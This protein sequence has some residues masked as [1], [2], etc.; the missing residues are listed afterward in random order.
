LPVSTEPVNVVRV[1]FENVE[2]AKG[3]EPPTR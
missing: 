1:S 3:F 2:L